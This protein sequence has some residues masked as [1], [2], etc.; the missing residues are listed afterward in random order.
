NQVTVV[1]PEGELDMAAAPEIEQTL[2]GLIDEGK[3][4]LVVDL[5]GVSYLDS[6]ALG[7]LVRAMKRARQAGGD[8]RLC[9]LRGDVLQIFEMTRL[10]QAMNVYRAR[11]AAVDSWK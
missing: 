9:A 3:T 10:S 5:G 1:I 6:S 4:K 2:K 7:E 8:L 11:K